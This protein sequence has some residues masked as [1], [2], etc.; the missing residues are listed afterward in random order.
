MELTDILTILAIVIGP[1]AA[2]QIEKYIQRKRDSKNQ[3]EDI[4]KT[5][6]A[7]RGSV[8][9]YAHV[10]ALNRI[11]LEF[12]NHNKYKKIMSQVVLHLVCL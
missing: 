5:L 3:R 7:T 10:E 8:L 12:S 4:F 1:I 9:S 6:M 11:D 2:V